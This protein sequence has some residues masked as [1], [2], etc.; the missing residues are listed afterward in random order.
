MNTL[1]LTVITSLNS[2]LLIM[3]YVDNIA[4]KAMVDA[5]SVLVVA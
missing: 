1:P 2:A 5:L 4:S 3:C